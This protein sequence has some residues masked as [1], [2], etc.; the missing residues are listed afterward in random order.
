MS[1]CHSCCTYLGIWLVSIRTHA[2]AQHMCAHVCRIH[3]SNYAFLKASAL[4]WS[5]MCPGILHPASG[6]T[7][8][9]RVIT[10]VCF[11]LH[12]SYHSSCIA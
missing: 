12:Y 2:W 4:D 7:R 9:V 3:D 10:E 11:I 8:S 1:A 5:F 6:T